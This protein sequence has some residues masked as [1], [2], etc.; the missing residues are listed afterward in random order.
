V[1]HTQLSFSLLVVAV[2]V[3]QDLTTVLLQRKV[4]RAVVVAVVKPQCLIVLQAHT[5]SLLVV[6]EVREVILRHQVA[7]VV[8]VL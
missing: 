8:L 5:Q 3:V 7:Q 1:L 6:L 4:V 2:V